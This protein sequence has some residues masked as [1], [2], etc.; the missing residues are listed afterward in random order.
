MKQLVYLLN[1]QVTKKGKAVKTVFPFAIRLQIHKQLF[2]TVLSRTAL[3]FVTT[4][5][6]V[7]YVKRSCFGIYG[8]IF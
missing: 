3:S 8:I 7:H 2:A 4:L 5:L 1:Y 6:N